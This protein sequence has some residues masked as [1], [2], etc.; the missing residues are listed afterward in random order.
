[1]S[2]QPCPGPAPAPIAERLLCGLRERPRKQ[3]QADEE[4]GRK[5][6]RL[7][8]RDVMNLGDLKAGQSSELSTGNKGPGVRSSKPRI[9]LSRALGARDQEP[10]HEWMR[11]EVPRDCS[12]GGGGRD[13]SRPAPAARL[14]LTAPCEA[15]DSL[16]VVTAGLSVPP[17]HPPQLQAS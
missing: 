17:S 8:R 4:G 9:S 15:W 11:P 13:G 2:A 5:M 14:L 1:M 12:G 16:F 7:A 3:R 6:I 10:R